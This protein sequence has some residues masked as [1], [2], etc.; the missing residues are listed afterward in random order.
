MIPKRVARIAYIAITHLASCLW[1]LIWG[2]FQAAQDA[3]TAGS[4]DDYD[5]MQVIWTL[6]GETAKAATQ[7]ISLLLVFLILAANSYAIVFRG[8][9]RSSQ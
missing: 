2:L 6:A 4:Y 9:T 8:I 3:F 5:P 7:S 1:A